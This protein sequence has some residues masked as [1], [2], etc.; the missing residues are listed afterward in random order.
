[1]LVALAIVASVSADVYMQYPRGSNCRLNGKNRNRQNGNRMF[2]SQNNDRGGYNVG[3]GGM[4]YY[5]GSTMTIEWTNQ[6]QCGGALG[7]GGAKSLNTHCELILQYMCST[8]LRDGQTTKTIPDNRNQCKDGNCNVDQKYG[9][10]E[11][12]DYYQNCKK[13]SRNKGLFTADQ[14]LNNK[15][16]AKNTRQNPNGNRRAYECPEER[17][18]YPYWGPAPWKDIAIMTTD[19]SRCALYKAESHNVKAKGVCVPPEDYNSAIPITKAACEALTSNGEKGVWTEV[20]AHGIPAPE[21]IQAPYSRDNH[22]GNGVGGFA[23][24]YNWTIPN[25]PD[26]RGPSMGCAL[27]LRYNISTADFDGWKEDASKNN[28][29]TDIASLVGLPNQ[30][31]A[32]ARGYKFEGNPNVK[33]FKE[34]GNKFTLQLAVNTAQ[35]ARTFQDRSHMWTVRERPAS[36]PAN[37]K[38]HNLNVKGKRG[39]I[40]QTYPAT[41]YDFTPNRLEIKAGD[42]VHIQWD[43]SNDN[44]KNNAGQG[45]A[46]TDR[47]NFVELREKKYP[48]GTKNIQSFGG[49]GTNYPQF[50]KKTNFLGMESTELVY[51]AQLPPGDE[52]DNASTYG[53][54]PPHKVTKKGTYYYMCTRNNNFTN[55]SQKGSIIVS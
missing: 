18:Y 39:N 12:Y 11:D 17:D 26:M 45:T 25:D 30:E 46:G 36:I 31:A 3:S 10:H 51:L 1:M 8:T 53:N 19:T 21:C 43:G 55:R 15:D 24:T 35:F 54:L 7:P 27:R 48:E 29:K 32:A 5:P 44:P 23:N 20:P 37:A 4:H 9:M 16:R 34:A 42:Y 2:D 6:H 13:R 28:E 52:L 47:S 38:I 50:L 49:W 22:L 40:V 14:N 33:A 41:E